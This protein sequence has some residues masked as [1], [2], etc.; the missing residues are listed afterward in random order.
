MN[1][2]RFYYLAFSIVGIILFSVMGFR[3]IRLGYRTPV[4]ESTRKK[5]G[6]VILISIDTLRANRLGCYG[7]A[8]TISPNIDSLAKESVL[9]LDNVCQATVTL[10][11]HSSLFTSQY[12]NSLGVFSEP[13]SP[14]IP[15]NRKTLIEYVKQNGYHTA[16]FTGGGFMDSR[17]GFGRGADL[18]NQDDFLP[19]KIEKVMKVI[20]QY[21]L[22][23]GQRNKH[24]SSSAVEA[25]GLFIFFHTYK[26]HMPYEYRPVYRNLLDNPQYYN[27]FLELLT[28]AATKYKDIDELQYPD[29]A[30]DDAVILLLGWQLSSEDFSSIPK[31]DRYDFLTP[32]AGAI[33]QTWMESPE[34]QDQ[35]QLMSGTYDITVRSMDAALGLLINKL[36][37]LKLWDEALIIFLADHGEEFMEHQFLGHYQYFYYQNL[38]QVPLLIKYPASFGIPPGLV[39]SSTANLDVLP[40]IAEVCGF[41]I[42]PDAVGKSLV[43]V[44]KNP[45][46]GNH[47][48][49]LIISEGFDHLTQTPI[50]MAR[51]GDFKAVKHK[52]G[53]YS[54]FDLAEDPMEQ[55]DLVHAPSEMFVQLRDAIERHNN[56][57]EALRKSA[58]YDLIDSNALEPELLKQKSKPDAE[59]EERLR[60]LG[61]IE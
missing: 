10:P 2:R 11:S 9:F 34:Y 49:P 57:T 7:Y 61:Y 60:Q 56:A 48:E 58:V 18:V 53:S 23:Y 20:D 8:K 55:H 21:S 54:F 37:M 31:L 1:N 47:Q 46:I 40:T 30:K 39:D 25:P 42:D 29:V 24:D 45:N 15:A 6:V 44:S 14:P 36:K 35:V 32:H 26:V 38:V 59:L 3:S 52:N 27:R 5:P 43:P 19:R 17:F 16:S 12:P 41:S 33:T 22:D 13:S 51:Q 50:V 28:T 4:I